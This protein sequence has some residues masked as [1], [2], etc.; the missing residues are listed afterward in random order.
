[1][2]K[3]TTLFRRERCA[4]LQTLRGLSPWVLIYVGFWVL[5][6]SIGLVPLVAGPAFLIGGNMSDTLTTGWLDHIQENW[7][8][9]IPEHIRVSDKRKKNPIGSA[10]RLESDKLEEIEAALKAGHTIYQVAKM[11]NSHC[12]TVKRIH[13]NK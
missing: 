2:K 12:S 13:D 7:K 8:S 1:M 3:Q 9:H 5:T 4:W 11:T 6:D 10:V